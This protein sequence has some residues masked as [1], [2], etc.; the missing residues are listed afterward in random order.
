MNEKQQSDSPEQIPKEPPPNYDETMAITGYQQ[1]TGAPTSASFVQPVDYG[2]ASS[3]TPMQPTVPHQQI[4]VIGGCPACRIG[5]LEEHMTLLGILCG[6]FFFPLGL[7]CC[8][9]LTERRCTN[10]GTTFKS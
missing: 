1:V 3:I 7:I 5:A 8:L 6:I 10:C 2:T 4:I 9:T